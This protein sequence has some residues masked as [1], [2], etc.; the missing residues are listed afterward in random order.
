LA[1]KCF[2]YRLGFVFQDFDLQA[3][4][5]RDPGLIGPAVTA[6][7]HW[8]A[9]GLPL[10]DG[11]R[12]VRHEE[13]GVVDH[14]AYGA[15]GRRRRSRPQMQEDHD[16]GEFHDVESARLG[17]NAAERHENLLVGLDVARIQMPVPHRYAGFVRRRRLREGRSRRQL[18]REP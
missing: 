18:R 12:H 13:A 2:T 15:A 10:G 4:R 8:Q 9:C 7:L 14:G 16:A 3:V 5:R 17:G 6:G 11:L 1:P